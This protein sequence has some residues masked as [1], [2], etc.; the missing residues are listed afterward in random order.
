MDM[1]YDTIPIFG[2]HRRLYRKKKMAYMITNED[3]PENHPIYVVDT[4]LG[5]TIFC[6]NACFEELEQ[7]ALIK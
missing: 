4:N 2:T 5:S 6:N 1:S 7:E 3:N